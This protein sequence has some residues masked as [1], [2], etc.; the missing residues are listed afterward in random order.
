MNEELDGLVSL[1]IERGRDFPYISN[2]LKEEGYSEADIKS[3]EQL[4]NQKKNPKRSLLPLRSQQR[5]LG[6]WRWV[7]LALESPLWF[8]ARKR[9][10]KYK[11]NK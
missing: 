5:I 8:L 6:L 2:V 10:K 11:D 3:A 7:F 9:L 4:Y 1:G